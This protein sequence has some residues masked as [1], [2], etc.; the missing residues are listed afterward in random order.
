MNNHPPIVTLIPEPPPDRAKEGRGRIKSAP[1]DFLVEERPAYLP[2]GDGTHRFLWVEKE[3]LSGPM[4]LKTVARRLGARPGDVGCAGLKDRRAITRQWLSVP[5]AL[6]TAPDEID[7]VFGG[8]GRIT[9]LEHGLHTNKL[10]TGHLNGNGFV[11]RLL[12]RDPKDDAVIQAASERISTQGFINTFGEQRFG[13]GEN[14]ADGLNLLRGGRE[15]DKQRR[16]F[17]V[18]SVQ[19]ALFN[20]WAQ[21]RHEGAGFQRALEGDLLT[22][23]ESGGVFEVEDA[24][25]ETER[26]LAGELLVTGPIFGSKARRASRAAAEYER[27]AL[28]AFQLEPDAFDVMKKLALGT[29]RSAIAHPADLTCTREED[30]VVLRFDL[31]SGTYATVLLAH[32]AGG[33]PEE[34]PSVQTA[35]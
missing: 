32:L 27:A 28:A 3:D 16:R 9:L 15:R 20:H 12:E 29:R 22:K 34:G 19:S 8:T 25:A 4:L 7:G 18:S 5:A 10:R 11:I 33:A 6:P 17:L 2:C 13:R 1:A 31:K 26:I 23:I 21:L 30:A 14:V 35:S 24:E